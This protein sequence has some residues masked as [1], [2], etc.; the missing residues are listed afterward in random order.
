MPYAWDMSE[1]AGVVHTAG[2]R[3]SLEV[4]NRELLEL[5]ARFAQSFLRWLDGAAGE[6]AYP[7]LR[8]LEVLHCQ[9]PAMMKDL[10]E[11]L[12]LSARNLTT[13]ADGLEHE[14]L[15]R[16]VP[17]PTDRRAILL[18]LTDTGASAAECSLA[19]RL[20]EIGR[21][22]DLLSRPQKTQFARGLRTLS[23]GLHSAGSAPS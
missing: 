17:H 20:V 1:P 7:R 10:A 8:V 5:T 18:E 11:T 13:L 6:L 12:G 2:G 15:I 3:P 19:P 16:R 23:G 22:F 9:G 4:P 14:G 21:V